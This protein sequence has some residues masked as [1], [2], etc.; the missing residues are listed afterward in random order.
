MSMAAAVLMDSSGGL[1]TTKNTFSGELARDQ[2]NRRGC[3][4]CSLLPEEG[5]LEAVSM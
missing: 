3:S 1:I 4:A 2:R 5:I